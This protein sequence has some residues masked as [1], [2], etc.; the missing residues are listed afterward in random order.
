MAIALSLDC[1]SGENYVKII[2]KTGSWATEE[3][4]T[5]TA[6]GVVSYTSPTL[7]NNQQRELEVCLPA[8][9]NNIYTLTMKDSRNDSWTSGAWIEFKDINDHTVLKYMMT[10]KTTETVD[11]ALNS[12]INKNDEW[13]FNN[14]FMGG[15]NQ[16]N[17]ADS[18][19]SAF[20]C[21][22]TSQQSVGTQ[23]FRKTF[24][25]VS[26]MAAID[27][28]FLYSHGIVAYINGVEIFRDNMPAGEVSQGTMA[29]GS[30]ATASYHGVFRSA[31]VAESVQSVLAVELHFTDTNSRTMDFNAL[32]SYAAGISAANNCVPYY[33]TI[34]AVGTGITSPAVAFDFTRNAG[35]S[36]SASNLPKDLIATFSDNV[37]PVVNAYRIWPSSSPLQVPSGFSIYGG[38]SATTTSWTPLAEVTGQSYTSL[39]WKQFTS[40]AQLPMYKSMKITLTASAGNNANVYEFQFLVCGTVGLAL[41][42]PETTYSFYANHDSVN[43][44][45][46]LLGITGCSINPALPNGVTLDATN[47]QISGMATVASPQTTY[48]VTATSGTS[49]AS[50]T[51]TLTFTEC[52][53][54]LLRILRTYKSSASR[55]AFRIRNTA[56]DA[57][58]MEVPTGH[59][60][61]SSQD[62]VD[63][64]CVTVDRFDITLDCSYTYWAKNSYIYVYAVL[65]ESNEEL[66]LKA[67]FDGNQ[68]NDNT[69]YLRRNSINVMEDWFYKMGDVPG[70]W[71]D[72]NTSG[73]QQAR[74]GTFPA[75]TNQIQ[76]YKKTFNVESL[77]VVS[78]FILNIRYKYGCVVYLNGNEAWRNH[79]G[80]GD[81]SATTTATES[82]SDIIYH[83]VTLPGRFVNEDGSNPITLLKQGSNTIAIGLFAF[84]GQTAADFD[85]TVRLMTNE[86]EAHIWEFSGSTSGLSG[87]Y[88]YAFDGYYSTTI[89][90]TSCNTNYLKITL[91]NDR[92]EWVNTIQV[93]N[94]YMGKTKGAAQFNVY[95]RNP[96]ESE[97]TQLA[98]VTGLTYSTMGQKRK[99]YFV[100]RIPYNQFKFENFA[101]GQTGSSTLCAYKVQSLNLYATDV[102]SEPSP[103]S[104]PASTEIFKGIEMSELIPEGDGYY[105]FSISPALPEGLA[106][107]ASNGWVSGTYNEIM[108]PTPYTVTAH[109]YTGGTTTATFTLSCGVC[110]DTR[111]LM[112]IR[113]R[114]DSF[115]NENSWKLFQGRGTSG[116][117]IQSVGLFPVTSN[118]YYLDFCLNNGL[119]TFQGFDSYG[120]GWSV[121]TGYTLTVDVGEME[122]EIEELNSGSSKPLSV[123][124]T[125]STFFPFQ[126]EFTEWKVYQNGAAP[127]N[128]NTVGFDDSAWTARKAAE[129]PNPSSV[130]TYI[131]KSFQ[132]TN[133]DDYQV[134]NVRVK[135]AGGVAV[136]FNGNRVARFNLADD[137]HTDTESLEVH[138][139]T[140][141]SKFHIVLITAGVQEGTNVIAFEVHRP[142]GT[143]SSE[144][145]VFDATGVFGVE[146]CSTVIDSYSALDSTNPSSGTLAGIMDL[147]PSTVGTLP[148]AA[149]TYLE[150][151]VENLE[152]TKFN[153]F[154]LLGGSALTTWVFELY[155]YMNP[156][157]ARNRVIM[158]NSNTPLESR[159]KPQIPVPVGLAGFRKIRYEILQ[160]SGITSTGAIFTAYCKSTGAVCSG[161]GN[162]PTVGE[163][164]ISPGPCEDGFTGYSYRTCTGGTL[165]E[166]QTDMCTYKAPAMV[167]YRNSRLTLVKGVKVS[168]KPT[169]RNIVT[170]WYL[171]EGISLPAGLSLN[172][173]TGEI[174]GVPMDIAEMTSYTIFAE[175]PNSAVAVTVDVTVRLGRCNAEGV[176]P[177]T[178]VD[179][180]A[181][182]Q[183]SMQGSY[184]GSQTRACVLG[185]TDGVWQ[186][187]KGFCMS[188]ASL[189]ILIVIAVLVIVV[190][191]FI[192][193]RMGRKSKAV[194]GVKGKKSTKAASAKKSDKKSKNVKV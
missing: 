65:T 159:T 98:Q 89:S 128:W 142:V 6:N 99:A 108:N 150:W 155:G 18:N 69:Y 116:T 125:F 133:I 104:Y 5:I 51:V 183:C 34:T 53:G 141:F 78:G 160:A 85:A 157:D 188:I 107:D 26:G 158:V 31:G 29:S 2:K 81:I 72:D 101:S 139:S 24:A 84:S 70:N 121:A 88:T 169:Y 90:S 83:T 66:L 109:K 153:S 77:D 184:I 151:T 15:W 17:F 74:M 28:Q 68:N 61:P 171:D 92:R 91:N 19:W 127:D 13:K 20:V 179:Q 14:S 97:W 147:D 43:I 185:E 41:T 163:G 35:S 177:L 37:T 36:V 102:L 119:Y 32:L 105:G 181:E 100:T 120:D 192:L 154:N 55:E 64:F 16:Y 173:E 132:L 10:E 46:N 111:S 54:T 73:W 27:A 165:G 122:L 56:N 174:S 45:P 115:P 186:K 95:G 82:Y 22:T 25:G 140:V 47:C 146:T 40:M 110:S 172:Q 167:R 126:V 182:Y 143:S 103:L 57:L 42:Y 86:P 152:G 136:Y 59:T 96:G 23:Y 71:Y 124:T 134:L 33:D 75:S 168:E 58:L 60:Y 63:Y 118:Y 4:F 7:V 123:S 30:Y 189:A 175:N 114:A 137:F 162:Y 48:S 87:T 164:Q 149:E 166:V 1:T 49:S 38:D 156:E 52:Q 9:T 94:D 190:V 129:I 180:V 161:I 44:R 145:F 12:P 93:Q 11:F 80:T 76:L 79:I 113:F 21:G 67:R 112:T 106:I 148:S 62:R 187:A 138:D 176:F 130:T 191:V 135:Y 193:M 3:S 194:G 131:R 39:V 144:P 8:T 170:K 178:E 50:G 117:P